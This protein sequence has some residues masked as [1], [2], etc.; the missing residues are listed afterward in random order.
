[1]I[2]QLLFKNILGFTLIIFS[3]SFIYYSDLREA[4]IAE[5]QISCGG[6]TYTLRF[7]GLEEIGTGNW[8]S[9]PT[10]EHFKTNI[11]LSDVD[12]D[13]ATSNTSEK[14]II[15]LNTYSAGQEFKNGKYEVHSDNYKL[16][17]DK[18]SIVKA[19]ILNWEGSST[20]PNVESGQ[21]EF[22]GEYPELLIEFNFILSDGKRIA[23]NFQ[24]DLT[25]FKYAF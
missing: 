7:G 19:S 6:E 16:K 25:D 14:I 12:L 9:I 24:K 17:N 11:Y 21:V 1:M 18:E 8:L 2:K 22:V 10:A 4:E 13:D 3:C 20:S 5:N 23:G 15:E